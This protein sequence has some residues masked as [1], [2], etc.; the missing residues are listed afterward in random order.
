MMIG[1]TVSARWAWAVEVRLFGG[2]SKLSDYFCRETRSGVAGTLWYLWPLLALNHCMTKRR[3][4]SRNV[5]QGL[6]SRQPMTAMTEK[7][8][9]G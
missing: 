7:K 2:T 8:S 6:D 4:G 9:P 3:S 5:V 1:V